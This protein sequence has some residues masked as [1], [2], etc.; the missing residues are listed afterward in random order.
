MAQPA[1]RQ[2]CQRRLSLPRPSPPRRSSAGHAGLPQRLAP[3]RVRQPARRRH[4][5][6]HDPGRLRL[7]GKSRDASRAATAT[8]R[9]AAIDLVS[10]VESRW[11]AGRSLASDSCMRPMRKPRSGCRRTLRRVQCPGRPRAAAAPLAR[12]AQWATAPAPR[13][14]CHP[15][16]RTC[17]PPTTPTWRRSWWGA[18]SIAHNKQ[19]NITEHKQFDI[20]T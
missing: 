2:Q 20:I 19:H 14:R 3:R 6:L 12:R 9:A 7:A 16:W 10:A 18:R 1:A 11:R 13:R 5:G 8:I 17:T 15:C 4:G